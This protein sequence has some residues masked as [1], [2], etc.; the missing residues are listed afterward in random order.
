MVRPGGFAVV[1]DNLVP[2]DRESAEFINNF[3]KIRDPSHNW[4]Y[5]E[6]DWVRFFQEAGFGLLHVEFFRKARDFDVWTKMMSVDEP[7]KERLREMLAAAPNRA[8]YALFPEERNGA[9]RFYLDELLIRG[10]KP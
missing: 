3:E 1:I 5:S 10:T 2:E 9:L 7:T 6:S 8:R 4:S